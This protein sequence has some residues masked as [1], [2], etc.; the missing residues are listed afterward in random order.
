M[1]LRSIFIAM[2]PLVMAGACGAQRLSGDPGIRSGRPSASSPVGSL[3]P[4]IASWLP[5][6]RTADSVGS[7]R[8]R[9]IVA[10]TVGAIVGGTLGAVVGNQY[11]AHNRWFCPP[12][13]AG[14]GCAVQHDY[15]GRYRTIGVLGGAVLGI[16]VGLA[17]GR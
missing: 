11:A 14:I 2:L 4:L 8:R 5:R 12:N 1:H 10:A 7:T 9:R 6:A 15:S 13:P 3:H 17:V 16:A